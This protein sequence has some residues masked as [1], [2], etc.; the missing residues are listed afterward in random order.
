MPVGHSQSRIDIAQTISCYDLRQHNR[1]SSFRVTQLQPGSTSN[2]LEG[3]H[4]MRI[5]TKQIT[6]NWQMC[7]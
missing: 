2:D 7:I 1:T 3:K 4:G 5:P 6:C